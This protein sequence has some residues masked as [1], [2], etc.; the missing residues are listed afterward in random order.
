MC[1]ENENII[2]E[3]N[4]SQSNDEFNWFTNSTS[5]I[6]T[7]DGKLKLKPNNTTTFFRRGFGVL[8]PINNRINIKS[9]LEIFRPQNSNDSSVCIVFGI[10]V[11]QVLIQESTI[12][13]SD[14]SQGGK[15]ERNLDRVLKY[16]GLTGSVSLK[17]EF[18]EGYGNELFL[19]DF[20]VTD[21][22]YCDDNVRAYFIVK[23]VFSDSL[24]A[25]SGVFKLKEY[26][27][28]N[29]ETLTSDFFSDT[30]NKNS[31]PVQDWNFAKANIDGSNR[32]QENTEPNTFNPFV[33][34]FGLT[35]EDSSSFYG[36]KPL[37]VTNGKDYGQGVFS[38]GFLKPEI[39]NEN[40]GS[41]KG[42]FFLDFDTTKKL[43]VVFEVAI[44]QNSSSVFNSP[45][46]YREYTVLWDAAK[47]EKSYYYKDF[48]NNTT[49]DEN[50]NGF[51]SGLTGS[52][53]DEEILQCDES[54]SYSG[55][56]GVQEYTI[57]FGTGTGVC[58]I[59]YNA[60]SV[61]DKF[62][63]E[64]NNQVYTTGFVGSNSSDQQLIN[65]G[66]NPSEI[67]T[68]SPSNGSGRLTF[69]KNTPSPTTAKVR[70][71]APLEGTAWN[72]SGICPGTI[73]PSQSN[74]VKLTDSL[75]LNQDN[76]DSNNLRTRI[77][78]NDVIF[79][80]PL[81]GNDE[82]DAVFDYEIK[83]K[84]DGISILSIV[85]NGQETIIDQVTPSTVSEKTGTYI[86]NLKAGDVALLKKTLIYT[87]DNATPNGGLLSAT[88]N[89]VQI[90]NGNYEPFNMLNWGSMLIVGFSLV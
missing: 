35:Y 6:Q 61:P 38:F 71:T 11:G 3:L 67:N 43:K 40:L 9:N 20:K 42:A 23:D 18:K 31:S 64:W 55:N 10:Y 50:S 41:E 87:V 65:L 90:R 16:N 25:Q 75:T 78:G 49:H 86:L 60:A 72:L 56:S 68:A 2:Q 52:V 46:I 29:Q 66:I 51:L 17:I 44:N 77:V 63:I 83:Q 85:K 84:G 59:D 12:Y 36:G 76:T 8:D 19:K 22:N 82:I 47:C 80:I 79:G 24:T 34:D 45:S 27:V 7:I 5:S 13:Q 73:Q 15:M 28:D 48:I 33:S 57:D 81:T 1:N 26:K 62:D 53:S 74:Y 58:G 37:S 30:Q 89:S 54:F 88:R 21:F 70:I 4:F 14:I 39:L 69:N 32:V